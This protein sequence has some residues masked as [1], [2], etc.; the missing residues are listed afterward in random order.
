MKDFLVECDGKVSSVG[1]RTIR[2]AI[3][4]LNDIAKNALADGF[5]VDEYNS[6]PW[7]VRLTRKS[8]G[9]VHEYKILEVQIDD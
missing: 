4:F 8:D 5:R 2:S 6:T 3:A 1:Y 7:F 9:K